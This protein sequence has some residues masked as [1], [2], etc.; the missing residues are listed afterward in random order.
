MSKTSH[1][2]KSE[3][4]V[5]RMP[6]MMWK[7]PLWKRV[8]ISVSRSGHFWGKSSRPMMLIASLNCMTLDGITDIFITDHTL[9]FILA[10][11]K[12]SCVCIT[13]INRNLSVHFKFHS[14]SNQY[15]NF[16]SSSDHFSIPVFESV[17]G[18]WASNLQCLPLWQSCQNLKFCWVHLR[19]TEK[20]TK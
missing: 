14:I 17:Q 11:N 3:C 4:A 8:T 12:E 10:Y 9:V 7:S 18:Y 15:S 5:L 6:L 20:M 19:S 2:L 16:R 1:L 13:K